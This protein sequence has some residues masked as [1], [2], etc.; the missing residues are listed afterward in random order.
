M[1]DALNH[2]WLYAPSSEPIESQGLGGD[3]M[4]SVESF[5][6]DEDWSRAPSAMSDSVRSGSRESFSQPMG[7]LQLGPDKRKSS[8]ILEREAK[9]QR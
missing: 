5:S 2:A 9:R 1:A 4:Y 7:N 3:S 8:Q 6:E